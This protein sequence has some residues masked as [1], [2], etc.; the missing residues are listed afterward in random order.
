MRV[1]AN[2]ETFEVVEGLTVAEFTRSRDLDPRYVVVERNGEALERR[3]YDEVRLADGD[4]LEIV[5]AVAGG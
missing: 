5:R 3:R 4:R 2:G 1:T